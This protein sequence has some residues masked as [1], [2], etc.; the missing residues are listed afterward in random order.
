MVSWALAVAVAAASMTGVAKARP[1]DD[2]IATG[3]LNVIVYRDNK[4]YSW[5]TD[6]GEV[7]GIDA[8]LA[9]A[10]AGELKVKANVIARSAGEEVDDDIRSNI[11]QGPRT[12]GIK[13]DVMMHV[14]LD[15]ELIARNNLAALS[16]PYYHEETVIAV[17]PVK[18][19]GKGI[20]AFKSMK[21]AVRFS[22]AAHYFLA[23]A[24]DGAY[25][26][27]VSPWM[28]F[29]DAAAYFIEGKAAGLAG[30]RSEVE[31]ALS[32]SG[33]KVEYIVPDIPDTLRSRWNVGT[34]VN[35][36][37][38]DLGY[39]IGRALRKLAE[40]GEVARIFEKHGASYVPPP[41]L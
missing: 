6:G 34:A 7:K 4:P 38:R 9:R 16:N 40:A 37:S 2:V 13:G 8:D 19:A 39:A 32:G 22:N 27:N 21:V 20:D 18:T 12:G 25:R 29:D 41:T 11:W 14:P 24:N 10:I 31:A 30:P 28:K 1:L 5:E 36:D 23:F 35:L 17:D 15:P 26:E 33:V 3:V